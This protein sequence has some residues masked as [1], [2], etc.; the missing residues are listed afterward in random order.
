MYAAFMTLVLKVAAGLSKK[1]SPV[2]LF[3]ACTWTAL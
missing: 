2:G 3:A 1:E